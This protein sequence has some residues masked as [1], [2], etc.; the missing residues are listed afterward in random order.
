MLLSHT[1]QAKL[2]P[3][4]VHLLCGMAEKVEGVLASHL[5]PKK[6][7]I[8][9]PSCICSWVKDYS[10]YTD[11]THRA[12]TCAQH[13]VAGLQLSDGVHSFHYTCDKGYTGHTFV[14]YV[15]LRWFLLCIVGVL[16]VFCS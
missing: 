7:S 6:E 13:N 15:V 10:G 14:C 2:F 11:A 9:W 5:N 12:R 3:L 16:C 8:V 4:A 1:C